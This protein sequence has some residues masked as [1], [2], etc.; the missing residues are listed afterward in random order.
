MGVEDFE[1]VKKLREERKKYAAFRKE[2]SEKL[3]KLLRE[4]NRR[5]EGLDIEME[6]PSLSVP[7]EYRKYKGY[8]VYPAV[9]KRSGGSKLCLV[10]V[11]VEANVEA[12]EADKIVVEAEKAPFLDLIAV[13][14]V[15]GDFRR[16]LEDHAIST[17]VEREMESHEKMIE[18][19][20]K[21]TKAY[22][23]YV[24]VF[25]TLKSV[26]DEAE[27]PEKQ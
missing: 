4:I 7:S 26:V 6:E 12:T 8:L 21:C 19:A 24:E 27:T 9:L 18:F 13:S 2:L 11:P 17:L 1:M 23:S 25:E 22:E 3:V 10:Y 5:L 16:L 20:K 14:S 15:L